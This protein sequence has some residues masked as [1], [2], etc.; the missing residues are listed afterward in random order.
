MLSLGH[1]LN[2]E[3][4]YLGYSFNHAVE[5]LINRQCTAKVQQQQP[6]TTLQTISDQILKPSFRL[7]IVLPT[8]RQSLSICTLSISLSWVLLWS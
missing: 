1:L 8:K 7:L 5:H 6:T 3:Y 4:K 2:I